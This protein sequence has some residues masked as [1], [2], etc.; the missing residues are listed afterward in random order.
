[1][2]IKPNF[3]LVVLSQHRKSKEKT[4]GDQGVRSQKKPETRQE[5]LLLVVRYPKHRHRLLTVSSVPIIKRPQ[6]LS[7][8]I[9]FVFTPTESL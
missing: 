4:R 7:T 8:E 6:V 9:H 1:M 2:E 5:L 3:D